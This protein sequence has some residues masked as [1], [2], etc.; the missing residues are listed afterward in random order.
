[1]RRKGTNPT[2]SVF[3]W[4]CLSRCS[5][6]YQTT[7][8]HFLE[9][10]SLVPA[11]SWG[12]GLSLMRHVVSFLGSASTASIPGREWHQE[13]S[14]ACGKCNGKTFVLV[15]KKFGVFLLNVFITQVVS[16]LSLELCGG[17]CAGSVFHSLINLSIFYGRT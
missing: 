16:E 12:L 5:P 3:G 9:V 4:S 6:V 2:V 10:L 17:N 11:L 7:E 15:Q 1:M 14:T 8:I 13:G